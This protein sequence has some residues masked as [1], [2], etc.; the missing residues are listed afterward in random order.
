VK[1]NAWLTV[2]CVCFASVSLLAG[3]PVPKGFVE[4]TLAPTGGKVNKPRGWFYAQNHTRENGAYH[5][6]WTLSKEKPKDGHYDTGFRIQYFMGV[7]KATGKT[8][9]QFIL[10]FIQRKRQE[11]KEVPRDC[12][13]RTEGAF[14][15]VCLETEEG[16]YHIL[17]SLFWENAG[18]DA[19]ITISGAKK[20]EWE[21]MVSIFDQMLEV[22]IID[23]EY[24][25][26]E[27]AA[28]ERAGPKKK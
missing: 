9:K 27:A 25:K 20:E 23:W 3:K 6:M 15:R 28:E 10:E 17:Y 4:Q 11:A 2:A 1:R 12:K 16:P 21:K 22:K 14:T 18:D 5:L 13:P 24:M 8:P 7:R 26:R 19:G